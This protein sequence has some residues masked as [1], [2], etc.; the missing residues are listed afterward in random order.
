MAG[1]LSWNDGLPSQGAT[2]SQSTNT[3]ERQSKGLRAQNDR[4]R[5]DRGDVPWLQYKQRVFCSLVLV[6]DRA[7]MR[8]VDQVVQ[9]NCWGSCVLNNSATRWGGELVVVSRSNPKHSSR[10]GLRRAENGEA[11]VG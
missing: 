8:V 10:F 2:R 9:D 11:A 3:I 6:R 4:S 5:Q 1:S 7:R